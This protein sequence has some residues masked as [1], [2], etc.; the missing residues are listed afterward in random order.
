MTT[1]HVAAEDRIRA[2]AEGLAPG[3]ADIDQGRADPRAAYTALREAGMLALLVPR[4]AGGEGMTFLEYTRA[5][6]TLATGDGSV[7]LGFNMHNV[8]IGGLCESAGA[9]L[10]AAAARFRDWVFDEVVEHGRMFASAVSEPGT[11]ARLRGIR[12]T[13]RRTPTGFVIDGTKSFVSLA[14]VAD[15]YVVTARPQGS[16]HADEVSH[17]VVSRDQPGVSF[18]GYWEGAALNATATAAMTLTGVE[19]GRERLFLGVE[20]MSLFKLVREPHWMAAG[21]AGAYLGMCEAIRGEVVAHVAGDERRRA[22]EAVRAEVGRLCVAVDAARALVYEA[23]RRVDERRGTVGA[24]T[25][26][27][28]AKYAVGELGPRLAADAVRVCGSAALRRGG[29]LERLR[30][31]T[32]FC[33][34]MP[35]KPDAC[36]DYVGRAALGYDMFDADGLDW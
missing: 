19:V 32:A 25:A 10:P 21:Y 29:A 3:A 4:S 30:R 5:L 36:L 27:H 14:G 17:F 16:E 22:S 2:A 18:G 24:N 8:A 9:E 6:E 15:H 13:Y 33:S 26:V 34:V 23:A 31:E 28:A 1:T 7:A 20:G 12:A 35:A 11:G